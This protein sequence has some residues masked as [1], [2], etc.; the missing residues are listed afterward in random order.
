MAFTVLAGLQQPITAFLNLSPEVCT[1]LFTPHI[2]STHDFARTRDLRVLACHCKS[3]VSVQVQREA[4]AYWWLRA[5]LAPIAL[6]N[7]SLSGILQVV[8]PAS[9]QVQIA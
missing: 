8:I 9:A 4:A 6:L 7:M 3:V 5:G 1:S 2:C